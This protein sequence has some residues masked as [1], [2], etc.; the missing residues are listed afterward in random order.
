[1]GH[2]VVTNLSGGA[3]PEARVS[4]QLVEVEDDSPIPGQPVATAQGSTVL[5]LNLS[6]EEAGNYP[7]GSRWNMVL[8]AV[9]SVS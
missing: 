8:E 9:G 4:V 3:S 5:N 7:I 6:L 1:M 2:M